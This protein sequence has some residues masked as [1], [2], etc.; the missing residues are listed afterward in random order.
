LRIEKPLESSCV[1]RLYHVG[2]KTGA[3]G[4]AAMVSVAIGRHGHEQRAS[5]ARITAQILGNLAP[6]DARHFQVAKDHVRQ[7]IQRPNH[8]VYSTERSMGLVAPESHERREGP[9]RIGFII[10]HQNAKG[11]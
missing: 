5:Q 9:C 4:T 6:I 3:C 2:V 8:R 10:D 11:S 1:H 7:K